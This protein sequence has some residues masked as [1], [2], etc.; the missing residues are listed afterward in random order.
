MSKTPEE[1]DA[2]ARARGDIIDADNPPGE[3]EGDEEEDGD[4]VELEEGSEGESSE[5]DEG[6]DGEDGLDDNDAEDEPGHDVEDDLDEEE[7]APAITIPKSRFDQAQKKA[8]ERQA[9][10]ER[11]IAEMEKTTKV[12]EDT[13]DLKKMTEDLEVLNTKFEDFLLDGEV[14]KA[15]DARRDRDS[16]QND[17]FDK[18]LSQQGEKSS[19]AAVEQMRFDAQLA[20]FEAK[21]PAI[22]PDS[23]DFNETL[24]TE[25]NEMLSVFRNSGYTLAAALNKAV[26]YV[27]R[28][29]EP[30]VGED[31]D[32]VR[33]KRGQKAR[34]KVVRAIK[35][36]PPDLSKKGKDS[37]KQGSGD[38]IPDA[39]KMSQE[40]F[41]DLDEKDIKAMRGD[42]LTDEEAA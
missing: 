1:L 12:S 36:S 5:L 21:F 14:E 32:V 6:E 37:D 26:H 30:R 38:G 10:L 33:S 24:V 13:T 28:D 8:R 18:R 2:E 35:Q 4:N 39:T 11:R 20:Q 17:I 31:P 22:N 42:R 29:D 41:E 19:G 27:V 34:K 40:G 15:R 3:L 25:V 16:L 7:E 9:E 23:D